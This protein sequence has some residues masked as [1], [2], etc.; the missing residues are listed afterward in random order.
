[1]ANKT[2]ALLAQ[3]KMQDALLT[4]AAERSLRAYIEQA[5]PILEPETTFVPNWHID[6][7]VEYLEAVTAGMIT[8]LLINVPPRS[9]KSLLVS[10]LWPT[11]EWIRRP[12]HRWVCAS[13][14]DG[15]ATKHSLDRRTILQSSWYQDRWGDRVQL[16]SDQNVKGEFQNT[17]R[18]VMIATSVGGSITGKGGDR[19]VVDDLHNPQQADSDAQ[20]ETA[21][22]YFRKTLATRL[23]SKKTG[24]IVVVKQRLHQHDLSTLCQDL[25]TRTC[26]CPPKRR[27]TP[28]SCFRSPRGSRCGSPAICSGPNAKA[29]PN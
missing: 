12:S 5:W 8:R 16:S 23:D 3:L 29:W 18:G 21:L 13:Y 25:G 14:A 7:L 9:M 17:K 27:A 1:M 10:V 4:R 26:R 11:W 22:A 20:R 28:R 6:L 15:L 2:R 19:I 24:T